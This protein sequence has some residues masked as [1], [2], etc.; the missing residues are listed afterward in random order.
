MSIT[1]EGQVIIGPLATTRMAC[2]M[3]AM[4]QE[5]DFLATLATVDRFD[6]DEAGDL[7][8]MHG[9]EVVIMAGR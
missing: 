6:I 9:N 5:H 4:Q 8:L 3:D 7:V 2:A 1:G